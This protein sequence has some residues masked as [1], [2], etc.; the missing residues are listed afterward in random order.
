[1]LQHVINTAG[2]VQQLQPQPSR[3]YISKQ[4]AQHRGRQLDLRTIPPIAQREVHA[5]HRER[6]R[7]ALGVGRRLAH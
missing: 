5:K 6:Q 1:M 2:S 3:C 4:H 7:Q